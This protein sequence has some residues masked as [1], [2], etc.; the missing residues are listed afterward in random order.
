MKKEIYIEIGKA[1]E[2]L[3]QYADSYKV[4]YIALCELETIARELLEKIAETAINEE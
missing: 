2:I 1:A 3:T 4:G